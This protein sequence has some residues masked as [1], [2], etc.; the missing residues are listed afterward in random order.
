MIE[1]FKDRE[2]EKIFHRQRSRKLPQD[3]HRRAYA[4]L[5]QIHRAQRLPDLSALPGNRFEW[6]KGDHQGQCS[7]RINDQWRVCFRWDAGDAY[8]VEIVDY[9]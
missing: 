7:I 1:S 2:I 6:L 4:K 9:H 3:I 8:E 5:L